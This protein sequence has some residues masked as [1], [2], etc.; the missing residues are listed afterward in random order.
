MA[1]KCLDAKTIKPLLIKKRIN[2]DIFNLQIR[3]QPKLGC[4][5]ESQSRDSKLRCKV[6]D[7]E[8]AMPKQ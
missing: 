5:F 6:V 1:F 8:S 2:N 7:Q 4:S 3:L